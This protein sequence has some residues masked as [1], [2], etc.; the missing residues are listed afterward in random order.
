MLMFRKASNIATMLMLLI[1]TTGFT[2][3]K[4]YCGNKIVSVSIDSRAES[5]C[6]TACDCCH[7]E[8]ITIHLEDD[9]VI[10]AFSVKFDSPEVDYFLFELPVYSEN[11]FLT[12]TDFIPEA[13]E[14]PP[15]RETKTVLSLLQPYI[16]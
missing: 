6:G 14:S 7:T 11:S 12:S 9:F 1:S 2:I 13:D 15:P 16:C 4:H 5:C 10:Q 8:N 3:S